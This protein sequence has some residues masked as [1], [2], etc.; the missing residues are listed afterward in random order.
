MNVQTTAMDPRIARIH[1][2]DYIKTVR[3]H[4]QEREARRLARAQEVHK[5]L[6]KVRVEKTLL[7]REDQ[8]LLEAYRALSRGARILDINQVI[9]KAGL[10]KQQLPVLA[11]ARADAKNCWFD[12]IN[13]AH[14]IVRFRI[15]ESTWQ[16]KT[17]DYVDVKFLDKY[18][19][20]QNAGWRRENDFPRIDAVKALVPS[21]PP[22]LRPQDQELSS[23]HIL[24]EAEWEKTAPT[25]PI[26]LK[27]INERFYTVVA[28][29]DLTPLERQVLEERL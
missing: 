20:L 24:W 1:Y 16:I 18:G 26:L 8:M 21:I 15:K 11:V 5:D 17:D 4:R 23:Y 28:Q 22:S 10:N 6:Y 9:T 29:W 12:T 13:S 27:R 14:D 3:K 2:S 25:D 7:E 19:N